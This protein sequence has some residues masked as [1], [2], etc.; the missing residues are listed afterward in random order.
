M[1]NLSYHINHPMNPESYTGSTESSPLVN[2]WIQTSWQG[3]TAFLKDT[4]A[5]QMIAS[6]AWMLGFQFLRAALPLQSQTK[7]EHED[8]K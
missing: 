7:Q 2:D 8:M 4:S 6:S 1:Y 3:F 5:G